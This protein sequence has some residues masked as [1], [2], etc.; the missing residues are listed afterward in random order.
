MDNLVSPRRKPTY[1]FRLRLVLTGSAEA[2][3]V[4]FAHDIQT[5][6]LALPELERGANE[7]VYKPIQL[8]EL[9][10]TIKRALSKRI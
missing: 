5:S 7:V 3:S 4:A 2:A 8:L 9:D 1:R 6:T 10:N